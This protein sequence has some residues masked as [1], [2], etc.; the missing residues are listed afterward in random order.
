[1]SDKIQAVE[2][3]AQIHYESASTSAIYSA[4]AS[5][6]AENDASQ[7]IKLLE[8]NEDTIPTGIVPLRFGPLPERGIPFSSTIIEVTPEEFEKIQSGELRL[9]EGWETRRL[10]PRLRQPVSTD[11]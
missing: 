3:L 7:P 11:E 10:V 1:M 2:K 8:V 4:Y 6:G 9:P 5:V